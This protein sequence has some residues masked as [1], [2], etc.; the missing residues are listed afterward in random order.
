ME[1]IKKI[2]DDTPFGNDQIT[3]TFTGYEVM[4][5]SSAVDAYIATLKDKI[6]RE[7]ESDDRV[8]DLNESILDDLQA[9]KD[10]LETV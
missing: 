2:T 10:K 3:I 6:E 1:I 9:I 7:K 5:I 4:Q 8:T